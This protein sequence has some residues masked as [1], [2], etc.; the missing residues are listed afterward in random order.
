[1]YRPEYK[2]VIRWQE[3]N[4]KMGFAVQA[5]HGN[6]LGIYNFVI[7][8]TTSVLAVAKVSYMQHF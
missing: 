2:V 1:M 3:A 6:T 4:G 5:F 8:V 7:K